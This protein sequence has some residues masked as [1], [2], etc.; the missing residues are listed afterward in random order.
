MIRLMSVQPSLSQTSYSFQQPR[1][2]YRKWCVHALGTRKA[3]CVAS[4]MGV[5]LNPK[6]PA[7]RETAKKRAG[8][9]RVG[10]TAVMTG[11]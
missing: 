3:H 7:G 10:W 1:C 9:E 8:E 2:I 6:A 5:L 4:I 11:A